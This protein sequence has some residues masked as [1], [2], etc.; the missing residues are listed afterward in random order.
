MWIKS[1]GT[2]FQIVSKRSD[3]TLGN[4]CLG[5]GTFKD[6]AFRLETGNTIRD[7][8]GMKSLRLGETQEVGFI[9]DY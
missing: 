7:K 9:S 6:G 8:N 1:I 2:F 4:E 3:P 5:F